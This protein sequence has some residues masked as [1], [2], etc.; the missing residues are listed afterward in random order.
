MRGSLLDFLRPRNSLST[1]S[2]SHCTLAWFNARPR[3]R[4][5]PALL[6]DGPGADV[7]R[8]ASLSALVPLSVSV[9]EP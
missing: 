8:V 9:R 1:T 4:R 5:T 7:D 6:V 2:S 3:S